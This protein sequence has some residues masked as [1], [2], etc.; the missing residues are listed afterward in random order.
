MF[1]LICRWAGNCGYVP[2]LG[3]VIFDPAVYYG[4]S[5]AELS[6]MKM[7]GGYPSELFEEYHKIIPKQKGF[8]SRIKLYQLYHYLNHLNIFGSGYKSSCVNIMKK[9]INELSD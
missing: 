1:L 3:P 4:H 2:K 6:I 7:F 8:N 5:E 9:L